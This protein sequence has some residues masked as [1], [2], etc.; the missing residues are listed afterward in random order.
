MKISE[1]IKNLEEFK[2]EYGDLDCWYA[3]DN[4]GNDYH[5]VYYS[6]SL[7]YVD[8]D[9]DIYTSIDDDID[10]EDLRKICIVN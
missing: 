3:T 7:C 9:D 1:M 8:S 10:E 5:E 2:A 6:P 4:E